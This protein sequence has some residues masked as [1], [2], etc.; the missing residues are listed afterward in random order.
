[1]RRR[2]VSE[3]C[4]PT[5]SKNFPVD[6]LARRCKTSD[7][8]RM[9]AVLPHEVYSSES[10]E[11][12]Q[13]QVPTGDVQKRCVKILFTCVGCNWMKQRGRPWARKM[14]R[15]V[16]VECLNG[17]ELQRMMWDIGWQKYCRGNMES[18]WETEFERHG[19]NA[20]SIRCP[21]TGV[22]CAVWIVLESEPQL[23]IRSLDWKYLNESYG[24]F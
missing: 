13:Q 17:E 4:L 24:R 10:F 16:I 15:Y 1:M 11:H 12:E 7:K 18:E 22:T 21:R 3:L 9:L 8:D 14:G 23:D 5:E 6:W 20:V 19:D 2:S